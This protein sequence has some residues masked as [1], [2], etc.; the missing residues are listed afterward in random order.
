MG[1]LD[2]SE[3]EI[4]PSMIEAARRALGSFQDEEGFIASYEF[5]EAVA[6]CMTKFAR[7]L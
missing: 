5:S 3:I 6:H 1:K 2:R 4:T 7:A